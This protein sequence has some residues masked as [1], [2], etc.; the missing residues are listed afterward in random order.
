MLIRPTRYLNLFILRIVSLQWDRLSRIRQ[1]ADTI[2]ASITQ[3]IIVFK[4]PLV[5]A[6]STSKLRAARVNALGAIIVVNIS[7]N[8]GT[9]ETPQGNFS[10]ACANIRKDD[11]S[12]PAIFRRRLLRI[13][14]N[15]APSDSWHCVSRQITLRTDI[16]IDGRASLRQD[17]IFKV[18][19]RIIAIIKMERFKR[20]AARK[21]KHTLIP[22]SHGQC[23]DAIGVADI[24]RASIGNYDVCRDFSALDLVNS[25][26]RISRNGQCALGFRTYA[27]D[28]GAVPKRQS[29]VLYNY[30]TSRDIPS[31]ASGNSQIAIDNKVCRVVGVID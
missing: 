13:V 4:I 3:T 6:S 19:C 25:R 23:H 17:E 16:K 27:R 9:A 15:G 5:P 29:L 2:P 22:A 7:R 26:R 14:R 11:A 28:N 12:G 21:I 20:R 8:Y 10:N 1:R 31:L 18:E 30:N 24:Q